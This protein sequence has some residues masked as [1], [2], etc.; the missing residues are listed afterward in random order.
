MLRTVIG[1]LVASYPNLSLHRTQKVIQRSQ[2]A[3]VQQLWVILDDLV[4]QLPA[5]VVLFCILDGISHYEA[6]H[7]RRETAFALTQLVDMARGAIESESCVVKL[8]LTSPLSSRTLKNELHRSE[9]IEMP[10]RV[11]ATSGL[12]PKAW[13]LSRASRAIQ[14]DTARGS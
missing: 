7:W 9:V 11:P 5:S 12:S 2:L 14:G 13:S 10:F 1:Q 6:S 3:D 4:S 8:L